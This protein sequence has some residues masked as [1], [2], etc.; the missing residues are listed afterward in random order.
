[1]ASA[2]SQ[3]MPVS[4]VELVYEADKSIS[5]NDR[6]TRLVLEFR[7]GKTP[8]KVK[9]RNSYAQ[10]ATYAER[11][12]NLGIVRITYPEE[13]PSPQATEI[14]GSHSWR[15]D[16]LYPVYLINQDVIFGSSTQTRFP[17]G[18]E[19]QLKWVIKR[20]GGLL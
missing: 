3:P 6:K 12:E 4:S 14:T 1:M 11:F 7:P 17:P 2:G 18:A 15:V 16:Q 5:K 8:G 13:I 10:C 9:V 20:T 19:L